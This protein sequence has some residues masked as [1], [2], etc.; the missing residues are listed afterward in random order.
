MSAPVLLLT[1][2][3]TPGSTINTARA[4]PQ[5]RLQDYRQALQWWIE[6]GPCKQIVLCDS[7]QTPFSAFADHVALAARLGVTFEYLTF[8]QDFSPHLGKGYGEMGIME[9]AMQHSRMLADAPF[10]MKATG[11]YIVRN[12]ALLVEQANTELPDIICDLREYLTVADCRCFI[13][14]PSF[15]TKYLF[16]RRE[17]CDDSRGSFLEHV[18]ARATHAALA[19]GCT[20]RL[21]VRTL[22]VSGFGGTRNASMKS[23]ASKYARL[24]AKR[25]LLKH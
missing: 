16:P 19:D 4:D 6:H 21:P 9:Y 8:Q 2:T 3:V 25:L 18:L 7:S 5:V 24:L 22:N 23:G 14:K 15:L 1:A 20:W 10:V 13:A 11:R 17:L 12:A